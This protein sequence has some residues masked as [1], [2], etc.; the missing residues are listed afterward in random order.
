MFDIQKIQNVKRHIQVNKGVGR[1]FRKKVVA[2]L[3]S[4]VIGFLPP[5]ATI[6]NAA[7]GGGISVAEGSTFLGESSNGAVIVNIAAANSQG[8]SHN[9]FIEFSVSR[10]GAVLNNA[11]PLAGGTITGVAGTISGNPNLVNDGIASVILNEVTSSNSSTLDGILEVAGQQASVVVANPNGIL[12]KRCGFSNTPHATLTT[13]KAIITGGQLDGFKVTGGSIDFSKTYKHDFRNVEVLDII[14]RSVSSNWTVYGKT[15]RV[16]AGRNITSF[17]AEGDAITHTPLGAASGR[18]DYAIQLNKAMHADQIS[19]VSTEK[20][21]GVN[22]RGVIGAGVGGLA[23]S[24]DGAIT[25]N[26]PVHSNAD[27]SAESKSSSVKIHSINAQGDIGVTARSHITL[28]SRASSQGSVVLKSNKGSV[29]FDTIVAGGAVN[30]WAKQE[31][32]AERVKKDL[33]VNLYSGDTISIRSL[34]R[35]ININRTVAEGNIK[36]TTN[37]A[38]NLQTVESREGSV[39]L[40]SFGK[41]GLGGISAEAVLSDV[42]ILSDAK[43]ANINVGLFAAGGDIDL[44]AE[45]GGLSV[46][47]IAANGTVDAIV[48]TSF[49]AVAVA[50]NDDISIEATNIAA[51][52]IVSGGSLDLTGDDS[53]IVNTIKA[54]EELLIDA[55]TLV[56]STLQTW[57]GNT[58]VNVT[59]G[60]TSDEIFSGKGTSINAGNS[61]VSV[62]NLISQES[63][64]IIAERVMLN[65]AS[66]GLDLIEYSETGSIVLVEGS[67][68]EISTR[69]NGTAFLE[70]QV[71]L[72]NVLTS[73]STM[74]AANGEVSYDSAWAGRDIAIFTGGDVQYGSTNTIGHFRIKSDGDLDFS[75]DKLL[76]QTNDDLSVVEVGGVI[77]LEALNIDLGNS[78]Y[79]FSGFYASAAEEIN[80]KKTTISTFMNE[81]FENGNIV[82]S[83]NKLLMNQSTTLD[84]AGTI[85]LESV[86][87]LE[88]GGT[89]KSDGDVLIFSDNGFINA[90]KGGGTID[91]VGSVIV[92]KRGE[93]DSIEATTVFA[94]QHCCSAAGN[95]TSEL[96]NIVVVA[97]RLGDTRS[98][99]FTAN[100]GNIYFNVGEIV[101]KNAW[102]GAFKAPEG[103]VSLA[104][105]K[106]S[107]KIMRGVT[108]SDIQLLAP[109]S[110]VTKDNG[111]GDV[112]AE[113][114]ILIAGSVDQEG[115][116]EYTQNLNI[117]GD[118]IGELGGVAI[119][120]VNIETPYLIKGGIDGIGLNA[121][122]ISLI[123]DI[124][125]ETGDLRLSGE[126]SVKF[127]NQVEIDGRIVVQSAAISQL[128]DADL[129]ADGSIVMHGGL[130]DDE[131][132][133]RGATISSENAKVHSK[134]GDVILTSDDINILD[135][136]SSRGNVVI[137]SDTLSVRNIYSMA[138][139]HNLL[140]GGGTTFVKA[141]DSM[142][143]S[144]RILSHEA[145]QI[146]TND[147]Q[148]SEIAPHFNQI[149]AVD[150]VV[151]AGGFD[152][153]GNMIRA[154]SVLNHR[155]ITSLEGSASI[156]GD[157]VDS[158]YLK[159][160]QG[161]VHVDSTIGDLAAVIAD[162]VY[163][164]ADDTLT[165]SGDIT[166]HSGI[167]VLS[168]IL[169][170]SG[171]AWT[172]GID[173]ILIAGGMDDTG[174]V[175]DAS[176][177]NNSA[178]LTST[179]GN[180]FA[181]GDVLVNTGSVTTS[182]GSIQFSM[183]DEITNSAEIN[184]TNG[185]VMMSAGKQ[186][187]N[188]GDITTGD[189]LVLLSDKIDLAEND[190]TVA[191][192]VFIGGSLDD[193]TRLTGASYF[194][195]SAQISSSAGELVVVA[196]EIFNHGSL[197]NTSGGIAI[198]ADTINNMGELNAGGSLHI[199]A[200]TGV[201]LTQDITSGD[202]LT[203]L[204]GVIETG[205]FAVTAENHIVL[206]GGA[207]SENNLINARAVRSSGAILAK[208]GNV[209]IG[210][211]TVD[212]RGSYTALNGSVLIDSV[213]A[214]NLGKLDAQGGDVYVTASR[215][216]NLTGDV[217]ANEF[218]TILSP[219]IKAS[220]SPILT[221]SVTAG[222]GILFAASVEQSPDEDGDS[223]PIQ[224]DSINIRTDLFT[225]NGD[226]VFFGNVIENSSNAKSKTGNIRVFADGN[227]QLGELSAE[228]G[229]IDIRGAEIAQLD[230]AI[231][232]GINASVFGDDIR[233]TGDVTADGMIAFGADVND[234]NTI[235][236][237]SNIEINSS[238]ISSNLD[239][240]IIFADNIEATNS[241]IMSGGDIL[242]AGTDL[243]GG[244]SYDA[245]DGNVNLMLE[246]SLTL[247]EGSNVTAGGVALLLA[248]EIIV[249]SN[250]SAVDDIVLAAEI[251]DEEKPVAGTAVS[252]GSNGIL[253]TSTGNA[254]VVTDSFDSLGE[255]NSTEGAI[256]VEAGSI[257]NLGSL[258]SLK[259]L[260]VRVS[261]DSAINVNREVRGGEGTA[262]FAETIN[263]SESGLVRGAGGKIYLG[264]GIDDEDQLLRS[265]SIT[266]SGL[267]DG[268]NGDVRIS[269]DIIE[270]GTGEIISGTAD[271]IITGGTITTG[272]ITGGKIA[273]IA[274][275][276]VSVKGWIDA[277]DRLFI[278][279][280]DVE[281]GEIKIGRNDEG[282]DNNKVQISAAA[283][284][285]F[286]AGSITVSHSSLDA[287]GS[288]DLGILGDLFIQ[289]GG[290]IHVSSYYTSVYEEKYWDT[291]DP[292]EY[293]YDFDAIG[294]S[295][296]KTT[297]TN[298]ISVLT[299]TND[300]GIV[301][302]GE[303]SEFNL[304][305]S[306][307]IA[308]GGVIINAGSVNL[309]ANRDGI[310]LTREEWRWDGGCGLIG[311][312]C[313]Y[314]K[315]WE[316]EHNIAPLAGVSITAHD[317]DYASRIELDAAAINEITEAE[318]DQGIIN[319]RD[320]A[321]TG[322]IVISAKG[323]IYGLAP[324]IT[325]TEFISL[326]SE[327]GDISIEAATYTISSS[328][329]T[330][331][332]NPT[333]FFGDPLVDIDASAITTA[334]TGEISG[335]QGVQIL[336]PEGQIQVTGANIL[337]EQGN[338]LIAGEHIDFDS[339]TSSS[340]LISSSNT[341]DFLYSSST[342]SF[343]YQ[344]SEV[345]TVVIA[346]GQLVISGETGV[347]LD[348]VILESGGNMLLTAGYDFDGELVMEDASILFHASINVT[349]TE[350]STSE[351][352]LSVG[353]EGSWFSLFGHEKN[354][355]EKWMENVSATQ[356]I[357]G[358]NILIKASG[359]IYSE[360][361][362]FT[363]GQHIFFEGDDVT[364][365]T[366]ISE[367]WVNMSNSSWSLGVGIGLPDFPKESTFKITAGLT[368][369][370]DSSSLVN[371]THAGTIVTAGTSENPGN[372]VIIDG[373][374][375]TIEGSVITATGDIKIDAEGNVTIAAVHNQMT[376][377]THED[378]TFVGF[379]V[380]L[381]SPALDAISAAY[382]KFMAIQTA[383]QN[384]GVA[385]EDS[386]D[387]LSAIHGAASI[388][389]VFNATLA[390][391]DSVEKL[392]KE[393]EKYAA[394][395]KHDEDGLK[396]LILLKI[397]ASF[398]VEHNNTTT[399]TETTTSQ[400]SN[401][402]A[403]DNIY[404]ETGIDFNFIGSGMLAGEDITIT[405]E[406][407][408]I[409]KP[410]TESTNTDTTSSSFAF[411][412][413][414]EASINGLLQGSIGSFFANANFKVD[415]ATSSSTTTVASTIHAGHDVSINAG[416]SLTGIGSIIQGENIYLTAGEDIS[417]IAAENQ[418]FANSIGF[419]AGI[420]VSAPLAGWNPTGFGF[421][422]D[423][424]FS[425][426]Y[427]TT[428]TYVNSSVTATEDLIA[429]SGGDTNII[430]AVLGG[431][432]IALT[433][434]GDLTIQSL[435]ETVASN[436][437]GF[438]LGLGLG[439][440]ADFMPTSV[441][442][443]FG[444]KG[445]VASVAWVE[446]QSGIIGT[447]SVNIV[448]QGD[449]NLIGGLIQSESN[450]LTLETGSFTFS[451]IYGSNTSFGAF[452][453]TGKFETEF[454][455]STSLASQL[456]SHF[457]VLGGSWD[458]G[459][460]FYDIRQ[461]TH[462]TISGASSITVNGE[463]IDLP[464]ALNTNIMVAQEITSNISINA[465]KIISD[466]RELN[467]ARVNL[468]ELLTED[469]DD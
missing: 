421:S 208:N 156:I 142:L 153:D 304:V 162:S 4:L 279:T 66:V 444:I 166:A 189:Q 6:A 366:V 40:V 69:D 253:T 234:D 331:T 402:I 452:F 283:I 135:V 205:N 236:R 314:K 460:E 424:K 275:S 365:T 188:S 226:I 255:V 181:I 392:Q 157:N 408:I 203:L 182:E 120:A 237:A 57:A 100:N 24:A 381:N 169:N 117:N 60:L 130:I 341:T 249:N 386:D 301:S 107:L 126:K 244:M 22:T 377:T 251:N 8:L 303:E 302:S 1:K 155:Y 290:D 106:G 265:N 190:L 96:G 134:N 267:I 94:S 26:K 271:T 362:Q 334:I 141:S 174:A 31:V 15:L 312:A 7:S 42:D 65:E 461:T 372:V 383:V 345:P 52:K 210:G 62:L 319:F 268:E 245:V 247:L 79:T 196:D 327:N 41:H 199:D 308:G 217:T 233:L 32:N 385:L 246:N 351:T 179:S 58:T 423:M 305:S 363:A 148:T 447:E 352:G 185:F 132:L 258:L 326:N 397:K 299:A 25:L 18:P 53:I 441:S 284:S 48:K 92:A 123:G 73:G 195:S 360:A 464:H 161:T 458:A 321:G 80:I 310:D 23:L 257:S 82:L 91:A 349:H 38:I 457:S 63:A 325:T 260:V 407:D 446:D 168:D 422:L 281:G 412:I 440:D 140:M 287:E 433:V 297:H 165:V 56:A 204:G 398:G 143:L 298:L 448:V 252:I 371:L 122:T 340:E 125:I 93:D 380:G 382:K 171:D 264:R 463:E 289:A 47:Q 104:I 250:V 454:G 30:I 225:T 175:S 88:G 77:D 101:N 248:D 102:Q 357:A 49:G 183:T 14:A 170:A 376:L 20:G 435:Q 348:T 103:L 51:L 222:S 206:S 230:G 131:I 272:T 193:E 127:H 108:G 232:A 324:V 391:Q 27:V 75:N 459:F 191:K 224:A 115:N 150:N 434:G 339:I 216:V 410:G 12:C 9:K 198:K 186:I 99:D 263:I 427:A 313:Q 411:N 112:I 145:I 354:T 144:G 469:D 384:A 109:D 337:S 2:I 178:D 401:L 37:K 146:V 238:A 209:V 70:D 76:E 419:G 436:M 468:I 35:G 316:R 29:L 184:A 415:N 417:F 34:G 292:N 227:V 21:L 358:G 200:S 328:S 430:G 116:L 172:A 453:D 353:S 455:S 176:Q 46:E 342:Y 235:A 59:D 151:I 137:D 194:K 355:V 344:E 406:G 388:A 413:G 89:L 173:G 367:S 288:A 111:F 16:L 259:H 10:E 439:T 64:N 33:G 240:V 81:G 180:I 5:F 61:S 269:A 322:N 55:G 139:F 317:Q 449:T 432:N 395:V 404:I 214:R 336:A 45:K 350:N 431:N 280:T 294:G 202:Q 87:L 418:T 164:T 149:K 438:H 399:T 68:L 300:I 293:P 315:V 405:S 229:Y 167:V 228:D 323:D 445:E 425:H 390:F 98:T 74:I 373:G 467:N 211:N 347:I 147:F 124:E 442:F 291:T 332:P 343:Y 231:I 375:T 274:D 163:L 84:A 121:E 78:N 119:S 133:L 369:D 158:H 118:I 71:V 192:D 67:D 409:I 241:Q 277:S 333:L 361:A 19:L 197:S 154:G 201:T 285:L 429:N 160:E 330:F 223:V 346:G 254:I 466:I 114:N 416:G 85:V 187:T 318:T 220:R 296:V 97:D 219:V 320:A 387:L 86:S 368:V 270:S 239:D 54:N 451:N 243:S 396:E 394:F 72:G 370:N 136:R 3:S 364:L 129:I 110:I 50:A 428:T 44:R 311:G 273:L 13:G 261:G 262:L 356:A 443:D 338:I 306:K 462:A 256:A 400:G 215:S 17:S 420:G 450:Q 138:S 207:D 128:E 329:E 378:Y 242:I 90:K 456:G 212:N 276:S 282:E 414:L 221:S 95:I 159:A 83:A 39:A 105:G 113:N 437:F 309:N 465:M 152:E 393:L 426:S 28:S 177:I 11:A 218:V 213:I 403:G 36:L 278:K 266:N 374:D 389:E 379:T 286:T 307:I 359:D 295:E 335:D 43:G